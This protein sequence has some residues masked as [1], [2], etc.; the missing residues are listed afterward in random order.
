[1]LPKRRRNSLLIK[2]SRLLP[3]PG[4]C[5]QCCDEH[6]GTCASFNSD[7]LSVYA[8]QWDF[9]VIRQLF[10]FFS[11]FTYMLVFIS[12][13]FFSFFYFTILYWF[14]HTSTWIHHG[15][16]C[17]PNPEPPSHLP[18][19]TIPLKRKKDQNSVKRSR[20][21]TEHLPLQSSCVEI[22]MP[23]VTY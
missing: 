4:Y 21:W 17:V 15:C 3:C 11:F 14:C 2:R 10:F 7:F 23:N 8:Q 20:L 9:W 16:T 12:I 6:W 18:P 1:M 13:F 19:Y 5:K 22:L